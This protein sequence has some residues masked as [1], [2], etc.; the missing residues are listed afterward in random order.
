MTGK[1]TLAGILKRL[2]GVAGVRGKPRGLRISFD[3]DDTLTGHRS[4]HPGEPGA[5]PD[6]LRSRLAEPL[7]PGTRGLIGELRRRGH[8]IW[9]YTT[10]SCTPDAIRRWLLVHGIRV[11]GVINGERHHRAARG[12]GSR[13]WPS[14]YPPAFGIDLHVDDSEGVGME[15]AAHGFRVLVVAPDD[16]HWAAK[17][18]EAAA[19]IHAAV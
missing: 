14:K 7:R 12:H 2:R 15:G 16:A 19:R 11:D 4:H 18:L 10:S 5:L 9:I 8:S 13:R 6:F 3:L 1:A 17:V